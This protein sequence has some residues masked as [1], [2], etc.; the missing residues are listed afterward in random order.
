MEEKNSKTRGHDPYRSTGDGHN[1]EAQSRNDEGDNPVLCQ[2]KKGAQSWE[3][4]FRGIQQEL[5]HIKETVK[6]RAPVSM[7]ALVQ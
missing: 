5:D 1:E 4:R 3:Q 2:P 6:G 7:D